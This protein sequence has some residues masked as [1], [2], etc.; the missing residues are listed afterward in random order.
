MET[1][2]EFIKRKEEEYSKHP[3]KRFSF[4]DISRQGK[5][6]WIREAW[7]FMQQYN[8]SEKVFVFERLKRVEIE[9]QITHTKNRELG[10]V[11]YRFGYYIIG[12]NG[13]KKDIWTWGQFCPLIPIE[14]FNRLVRLAKERDARN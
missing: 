14:D 8:L 5:H 1:A 13:T 7:V 4:K 9:G 10:D 6:F 12:K 11:E 3:N 2:E